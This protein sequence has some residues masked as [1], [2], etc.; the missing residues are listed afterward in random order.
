[1]SHHV[2]GFRVLGGKGRRDASYGGRDNGASRTKFRRQDARREL[3]NDF[4]EKTKQSRKKIRV[5]DIQLPSSADDLKR[6]ARSI[7]G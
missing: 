6:T 2:V 1:M 5:E 4:Q 3:K 7:G